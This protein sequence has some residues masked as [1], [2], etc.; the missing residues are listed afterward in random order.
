MRLLT[1][2][3][4]AAVTAFGVCGCGGEETAEETLSPCSREEARGAVD[5]LQPLLDEY[6]DHFE[7]ASST[8]RI[9]LAPVIG[10]IQETRREVRGLEVPDCAAEV[11]DAI[12]DAID[13]SIDGFL[14]FQSDESESTIERH[15]DRAGD[16]LEQVTD[17]LTDLRI[18]A[19]LAD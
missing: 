11:R 12:A 18:D 5:A 8:G 19:M 10:D 17:D 14:A 6:M 9:A 13:A 7:R 2:L 4:I 1:A 3:S 16:L 15:F